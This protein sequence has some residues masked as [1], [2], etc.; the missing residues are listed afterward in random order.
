MVSAKS[1]PAITEFINACLRLS[2]LSTQKAHAAKRG[3]IELCH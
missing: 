1:C 2:A 3:S